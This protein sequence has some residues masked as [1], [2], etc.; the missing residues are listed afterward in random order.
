MKKTP[1]LPLD[2]RV[3]ASLRNGIAQSENFKVN[4]KAE[5]C[6]ILSIVSF[7]A[8]PTFE[9]RPSARGCQYPTDV[10]ST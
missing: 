7:S 10:L 9:Q 4:L 5:V 8:V 6:T 2:A 3:L 1:S